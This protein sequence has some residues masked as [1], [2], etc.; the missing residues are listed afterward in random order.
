MGLQAGIGVD[1]VQGKTI[2]FN[3]WLMVFYFSGTGCAFDIS[4][5]VDW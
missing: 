3:E 1:I 5:L 2:G 4:E